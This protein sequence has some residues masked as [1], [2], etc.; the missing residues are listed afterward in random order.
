[1]SDVFISYANEDRVIA[2]QVANDLRARGAEVWL[3]EESLVPGGDWEKEI[4][5]QIQN[6]AAVLVFVSP[7]SLASK[8]VMR[9]WNFALARKNIRV[10]PALIGGATFSDMP[11]PLRTIQAVDLNKDYEAGILQ[12]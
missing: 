5:Q 11:T 8:W 12:I 10:L 4:S 6:T 7:A 9:E 2:R 1:M 3:D